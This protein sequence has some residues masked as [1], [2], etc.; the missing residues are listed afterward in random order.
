MP[1]TRLPLVP[2][3]VKV[4]VPFGELV[5]V[6]MVRVELPEPVTEVGLKAPLLPDGT[7]VTLRTTAPAKPFCGAIVTAYVVT[8]PR[9]TLR[10]DGAAEIE[11]SPV[12]GAF[13]LSV[14]VVERTKV[15]PVPVM[16]TG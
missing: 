8:A 10:E 4:N 15:P 14:T 6:E 2:V 7:P 3:I 13:T 5:L 11:K 1:C 12:C 16:V 9:F